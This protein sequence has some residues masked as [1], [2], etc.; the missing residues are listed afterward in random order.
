MPPALAALWQILNDFVCQ[1][2]NIKLTFYQCAKLSNVS[3]FLFNYYFK[4]RA[5]K[6]IWLYIKLHYKLI[7]A[8]SNI[9]VGA[10]KC[11]IA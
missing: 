8:V 9:N 1:L 2:T 4:F 7:I 11:C 10:V 5:A 3:K 6:Y